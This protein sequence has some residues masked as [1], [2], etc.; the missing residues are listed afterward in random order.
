[1]NAIAE[2]RP[3]EP[4]HPL[5]CGPAETVREG[6]FEIPGGLSLHHGGKLPTVRVAWRLAGAANAPV[7]CA[8]GGISATR[9]VCLTEQPRQSWWAQVAGP[10]RA[11]DTERCRVLSFDYLGGSGETTGPLAGERFPSISTYDQAEVLARLMDH[12]GL[13]SLRAIA[14]GSY[15]GMVALA[16]G[17]R[18]PERVGRLIVLCATD[19]AHPLGTAWR[20][21]QRDIVRFGI[22][23]GQPTQA[24]ALA[25]SLA[26]STYRSGE[27][28]AARFAG[29]ATF[30]Q[31]RA[32]FPVE[33]YLAARGADYAAQHRPEAFLCLSESIDLHRVEASRIC[34][35]TAAV[36][37]REDM[38]V[39]L[40]EVR[41]MVARL[42]AAQLHEISSIY[43]HDAFL[44]EP[45]QLRGVFAP[46]LETA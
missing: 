32:R 17:E 37:V 2:V 25:R 33:R 34:V 6:F 20:A 12:L 11:L 21:V 9:R 14:G 8:L 27:E 44:K 7:V 3:I 36:A 5:R 26:M 29:P 13:A 28:F 4:E 30:E 15:G 46:V 35:P 45:Q 42:H 16:F 31:G 43:G 18:F 23:A 41:A 1:M 10:G 19:R 40:S 22:E 39:P 38:L 24:L